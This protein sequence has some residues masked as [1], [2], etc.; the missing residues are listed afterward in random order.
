MSNF[1]IEV[2]SLF[3]SSKR[4]QF[5]QTVE[6]HRLLHLVPSLISTS[7]SIQ[8]S[9]MIQTLLTAN[10]CDRSWGN[11]QYRISA[12]CHMGWHILR[13]SHLT[14]PTPS[15]SMMT[16]TMRRMW[17]SNIASIW[18]QQ[19]HVPRRKEAPSAAGA[20][21]E[22]IS[23]GCS[24]VVLLASS[25][26]SGWN[27]T[28]LGATVCSLFEFCWDGMSW[29]S[30]EWV[31]DPFIK[32]IIYLSLNFKFSSSYYSVSILTASLKRYPF[33]LFGFSLFCARSPN[34]VFLNITYPAGGQVLGSCHVF[35]FKR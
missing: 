33:N 15:Y 27:G 11:Y 10:V 22:A 18:P 12:G 5:L 19:Q 21:F 16:R 14:S 2:P 24:G 6:T 4:R 29:E 25:H 7:I 34:I 31:T 28:L 23:L 20:I 13:I 30:V 8:K 3:S 9:Q 35:N 17:L 1:I 32:A 26:I